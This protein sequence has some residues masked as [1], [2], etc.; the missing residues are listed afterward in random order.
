MTPPERLNVA[1]RICLHVIV[2]GV[3]GSGKSVVA[4][5]LGT[6]LGLD[7]IDGDD[8]HPPANVDK[9]AAGISLADEDRRPWLQALAALTAERH[10]RGE[11][12]V[13]ACSA[14]RRRYRDMLRTAAPVGESFVVQLDADIETLRMRM[15]SRQGHFMPVGLLD[16]QLAALEPLAPDEAGIVLDTARPLDAVVADALTEVLA[17]HPG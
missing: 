4:A 10:A 13:L 15:S 14:L 2:T 9:M 3:S 17:R 5:E 6:R 7:V 12:T 16:S 8:H 1:G 11:G